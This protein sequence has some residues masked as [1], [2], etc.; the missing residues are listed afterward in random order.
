MRYAAFGWLALLGG[1]AF[2][3][4]CTTPNSWSG[5]W[6]LDEHLSQ[7]V[8]PTFIYTQAPSGEYMVN[9]GDHVFRFFCDGNDYPT[10]PQRS[11]VCT[12]SGSRSMQMIYKANGQIVSHA[13]RT[14]SPDGKVLTVTSATGAAGT[15]EVRSDSYQRTSAS[16]GFVGAWT[17]NDQ[18]SLRPPVL[19]ITKTGPLLSVSFPGN[20]QHTDIPL[21]GK[22][23]VIQGNATGVHAILSAV[24]SS[25]PRG[26]ATRVLL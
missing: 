22:D 18:S 25:A 23:A 3:S 9:T 8:G 11:L 5:T 17:N 15:E 14:L 7:P 13:I 6:K 2:A 12:Q 1:L 16:T 4:A 10:L 24:P 26:T 21:N 20:K 19:I